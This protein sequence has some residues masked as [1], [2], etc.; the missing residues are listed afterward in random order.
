M[1]P[2]YL[3]LCLISNNNILPQIYIKMDEI[4][5]T[6]NLMINKRR[7]KVKNQVVDLGMIAKTTNWIQIPKAKMSTRL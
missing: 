7:L 2:I 3:N 5:K 6:Q 1:E 4:K